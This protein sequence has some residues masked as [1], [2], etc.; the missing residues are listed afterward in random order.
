SLH[1]HALCLPQPYIFFFSLILPRPPTSTLFPYTTLFR[2]LSSRG[3]HL[4][5]A[6]VRAK[7]DRVGRP[8]C[9]SKSEPGHVGDQGRWTATKRRSEEHTSELQSRFDLVC[10][11]LLEKKKYTNLNNRALWSIASFPTLATI[12]HVSPVT[13]STETF[14]AI[15]Y[16]ASLRDITSITVLMSVA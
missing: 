11:L 16:L 2:S 10:R 15:Q 1:L 13:I 3:G 6:P 7:H 4:H 14:F 9:R 12:S 5:Q 8:P